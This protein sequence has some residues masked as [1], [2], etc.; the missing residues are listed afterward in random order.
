MH[1]SIRET[2]DFT[3]CSN[4]PLRKRY[5]F[6]IRTYVRKKRCCSEIGNRYRYCESAV[7]DL[8]RERERGGGERNS[9]DWIHYLRE[10][11]H[12]R[13]STERQYLLCRDFESRSGAARV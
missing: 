9:T 7:R 10:L 13:N 11:Y 1:R 12:T 6:R 3:F 4:V 8:T 2:S 5:V